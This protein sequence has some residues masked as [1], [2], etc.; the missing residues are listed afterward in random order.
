MFEDD[1][2]LVSGY[3]DIQRS[4][5]GV[6]VGNIIDGKYKKIQQILRAQELTPTEKF[7]EAVQMVCYQE[8]IGFDSNIYEQIANKVK[9]PQYINPKA[10]VYAVKF[11]RTK[12][13]FKSA[14][15]LSKLEANEISVL[16][17][18]RY[19]AIVSLNR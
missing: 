15:L 7:L 14:E 6:G 18:Y 2:D 11:F 17:M 19:M 8:G 3:A 9:Y 13:D 10:C 5:F 1:N 12:E 4:Q 16:D